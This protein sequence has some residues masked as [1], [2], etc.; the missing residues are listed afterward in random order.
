MVSMGLRAMTPTFWAKSILSAP[1]ARERLGAGGNRSGAHGADRFSAS[2]AYDTD[3]AA[4]N[5]SSHQVNNCHG[6]AYDMGVDHD[7]RQVDGSIFEDGN[8]L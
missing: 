7:Y 1:A 6:T 8:R 5:A 2:A 3:A 4:A